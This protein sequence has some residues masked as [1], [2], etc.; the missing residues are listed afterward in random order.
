M[1]EPERVA[2]RV[3]AAACTALP[4][5]AAVLVSLA[6]AAREWGRHDSHSTDWIAIAVALA[7]MLTGSL[8]WTRRVARSAPPAPPTPE[9][10]ERARERL[11]AAVLVQWRTE[12]AVRRLDDPAP[13]AVRWRLSGPM[14]R[15][16]HALPRPAG[17]GGPFHGGIVGDGDRIPEL[18][19]R[20]RALPRRRLMITGGPGAGKTTLAVLLVRELL[21]DPEPGEPVP[22]LLPLTGWDP[23]AEPLGPWLARRVGEQCPS[24]LAADVGRD[25]PAELVG[26]GL[27]LP[28][29]DGLDEQPEALRPVVLAALNSTGWPASRPLVLTGRTREYADAVAAPGGDVLTGA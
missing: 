1:T 13:L 19:A 27:V 18:A 22:V 7:P 25:A 21:E 17:P 16:E 5:G 12:A 15:P 23:A 29:L 3:L 28:V 9:Q 11:A 20:F 8:L 24:L 4:L 14:D 26:R 10:V 6:E 2:L